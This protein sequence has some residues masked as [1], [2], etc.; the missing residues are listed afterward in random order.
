MCVWGNPLTVMGQVDVKVTY[1]GQQ[2]VLPQVVVEG[3]K[4]C[5]TLMGRD[6]LGSIT[7][8]WHELFAISS[9][10]SLS[11][12]LRKH[13]GVFKHQPERCKKQVSLVV[14][15]IVGSRLI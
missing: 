9:T 12:V 13:E 2:H 3:G 14:D 11:S 5:P 15:P 1:E 8:R 4:G 6:W 7:L 10:E